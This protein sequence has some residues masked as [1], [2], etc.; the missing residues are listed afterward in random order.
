MTDEKVHLDSFPRLIKI[1][2]EK[3]L[4]TGIFLPKSTMPLPW[5]DWLRFWGDQSWRKDA[6][7]VSA[8]Q[9]TGKKREEEEEREIHCCAPFEL[10][11]GEQKFEYA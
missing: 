2:F 8:A 7:D 6:D 9:T 5:I 10:S 4:D 3:K 1:V 11:R